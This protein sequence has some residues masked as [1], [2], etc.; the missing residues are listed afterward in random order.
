MSRHRKPDDIAE[1]PEPEAAGG[2]AGGATAAPTTAAGPK[3]MWLA[4]LEGPRGVACLS[5]ILVHVTVH[6]T[7]GILDA[8]RLD[9]LGQAL[10]FFFVLSGFLLYLPFV[11]KLVTGSNA[12]ATG[13]YFVSR[14]RRVFPAYLFIFVISNFVLQAS[15]LVS[16]VTVG[17]ADGDEGTGMITDPLDLLAQFTLTQSLFPSTLQTGLNPAWSLTTEWGFYLVLPIVGLAT[18]A[19]RGRLKMSPYR[20][21][22]IGPGILI[23]IGV[24]TNYLVGV[25]QAAHPEYSPLEA[26]WGP[27]WIAV[28]SRSFLALADNFAIGMIAAVV[29]VALGHGAKQAWSTVRLQWTLAASMFAFTFA[30]LAAFVLGSRYLP[31]F[32]SVAAASLILLIIAPLARGEESVLA[33][34]TDWRPLKYAGTVSLSMYLWHYPVMIMA[35]RLHLPVQNSLLGL[36]WGFVA[37]SLITLVLASL[38]F[39][40]IEKP[41]MRWRA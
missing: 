40:F 4:G 1:V 23:V 7:P 17:W 25:L 27:N 28:L 24:V 29:Y 16:P 39:R 12:P 21:A 15:Y 14:I 37:I 31:T 26:Y 32:F 11:K 9:F 8:T 6:Y 41:A 34:A 33:K 30:S 13:K 2:I 5:V 36:V 38:T 35:E 22:L 20:L 10:T 18:F 3:R 19:M